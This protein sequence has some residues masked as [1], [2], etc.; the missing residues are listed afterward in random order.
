MNETT[1]K[2]NE[3]MVKAATSAAFISIIVY[4]LVVMMPGII[5]NEVVEAFSLE[6]TDEGL[7]SA[8]TSFGFML[9]LFFTVMIQGRV[10]KAAVLIFAFALQAVMLVVCGFSPTFILFCLGC[11]FVGFSGG[12][13]DT[14][15][16]STIVDVRKKESAKYLGYLHGLFGVGSLLSPLAFIWAIRYIDWRGVHYAL[17]VASLIVILLI[18]V[19]TRGADKKSN[20]TIVREHLFTKADLFAYIKV[21]RNIALAFAGFFCMFA[22]ACTLVWI[23]RYTTLRYDAAEL[24]ALSITVYWICATVNRFFFAGFVKRAPMTFF[25]LGGLLSAASVLIGVLSGNPVVLCALMGVFGLCSGHFIP[26][27]V[28]EFAIGYDGRTTFTTSF[29]MF[30]MVIAR[31]VAPL[32]MAFVSTQIS[33]TLGMM[34]PVAAAL[35][36]MGSGLLALKAKNPV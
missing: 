1:Q 11:T 34:I 36:A 35:L 23:V 10:K 25:A 19:L 32:A 18:F 12:F 21:K 7:M 29:L 30:V 13:I 28:R 5:I 4:S 31:V 8:L 27:L 24:G 22:M 14:V 33:L 3:L 9:S 2:H 20:T 16:N 26:V 15:S 17:A 6:G